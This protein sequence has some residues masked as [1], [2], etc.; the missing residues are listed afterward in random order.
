MKRPK[1]PAWN[2]LAF[3]RRN[4]AWTYTTPPPTLTITWDVTSQQFR[5]RSS[6]PITT[7]V[8]KPTPRP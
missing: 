7:Q 3:K 6:N 8:D 4:N 1:I 5:V 2:N